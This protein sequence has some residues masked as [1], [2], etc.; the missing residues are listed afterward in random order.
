MSEEQA[1][2]DSGFSLGDLRSF[3]TAGMIWAFLGM[4]ATIVF[5]LGFNAVAAR[6]L[7][8]TAFGALVLI[9]SVTQAAAVVG[10]LGLP[11][12]VTRFVAARIGTSDDDAVASAVQTALLLTTASCIGISLVL[13]WPGRP[14]FARAFENALFVDALAVAGLPVAARAYER[15]LSDAFRGAHDLRAA[16]IFGG[17]WNQVMAF[18]VLAAAWLIVG[19]VSLQTTVIIYG[20]AGTAAVAAAV[21]M[22]HRRLRLG[23]S[24][25][26]MGRALLEES[27]PV[28]VN[29]GM[30]IVIGQADLWVVGAFLPSDRA[31]IY[32]VALRVV[33]VI[34][35]PLMIVNQ[36]V[37][38]VISRLSSQ[39]ERTRLERAL[40]VT[41]TVGAVPALV[42]LIVLAAAGA[43]LL[44]LVFGDF[45]REAYLVLVILALGQAVNALAGSAGVTL[46]QTGNQR[47]LMTIS[48]V[49]GGLMVTSAVLAVE[50]FGIVGVAWAATGGLVL[51]NLAM[52]VVLRRRAGLRT[53]ID[54]GATLV[55]VR[56]L[57]QRLR[58]DRGTTDR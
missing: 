51:Q 54:P 31:A 26:W 22:L 28:L 41:A 14:L 23:R 2:S 36:V 10:E 52:V 16:S 24:R 12:I 37:P 53:Y 18:L 9:I 45:Y 19:D 39:G 49:S 40:R 25:T 15:L 29:R 30:Y 21:P 38:P 27:W 43:P 57:V 50:R 48:L 47:S 35:A 8:P 58:D 44:G 17:A 34:I 33:L 42:A 4:A 3:V 32:G 20:G 46:T 5:G 11:P 6:A 55:A 1:P 13:W 7:E 56:N